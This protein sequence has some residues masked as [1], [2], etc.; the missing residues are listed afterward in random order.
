MTR[1]TTPLLMIIVLS[2]TPLLFIGGVDD[3]SYRSLKLLWNLGHIPFFYLWTFL[4]LNWQK[5]YFLKKPTTSSLL[6]A[7]LALTAGLS[8][9]YLQA[10]IGRQ[11]S[12]QD[13]GYD[14]TG[15]ILAIGHQLHLKKIL[16]AYLNK[17]SGSICL[18][19][20]FAVCIPSIIAITD[21]AYAYYQFPVLA[22]FSSPF[23][24]KRFAGS[25]SL[26]RISE[27]RN[28]NNKLIRVT[29]NTDQYSSLALKYFIGDWR[30]F[31]QLRFDVLNPDTETLQLTCRIH[32][33]QHRQNGY[34]FNDR[35]N[36]HYSLDKGWHQVTIALDEVKISPQG[37]PMDLAKIAGFSCF[38]MA[39]PQVREVL[40]DNF[41]L[42][43]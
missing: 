39:L 29:F 34:N 11:F 5:T 7:S 27:Q 43:N 35:F 1:I 3:S 32:D 20:F 10:L 25:G 19:L 22:D 14:M 4:F 12:W 6:V 33:Q 42:A 18:L 40:F 38:T 24:T 28:S 21:E 26:S 17:I 13:L 8:I 30:Q 31:K 37:R 41:R 23:E 9:E 15:A 2:T 16:P 36:R